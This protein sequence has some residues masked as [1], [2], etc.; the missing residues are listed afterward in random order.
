MVDDYTGVGDGCW[1]NKILSPTFSYI[2][3]AF[4]IPTFHF[5]VFDKDIDGVISKQEFIDELKRYL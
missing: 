4:K 1:R 5:R 2:F 3:Q